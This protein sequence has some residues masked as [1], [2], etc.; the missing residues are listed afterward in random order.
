MNKKQLK[1]ITDE[2]YRLL[3]KHIKKVAENFDADT[4][5]QMRVAYKKLRAFFRMINAGNKEKR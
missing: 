5:H 1:H 3:K 4:I 2:H